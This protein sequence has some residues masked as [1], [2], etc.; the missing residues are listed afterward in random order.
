[1]GAQQGLGALVMKGWSV[2]DMSLVLVTVIT[3]AIIGALL[4]FV[5]AKA[6]RLVTPWNR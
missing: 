4:A 6:E 5:L 3:I 1:M 2:M